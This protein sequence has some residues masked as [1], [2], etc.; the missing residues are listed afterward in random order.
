MPNLSDDTIQSGLY[1]FYN[2]LEYLNLTQSY[3][4]IEIYILIAHFLNN[5][6]LSEV[7]K[8]TNFC[9]KFE[10]ISFLFYFFNRN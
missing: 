9:Q 2:K 10:K 6:P 8:V 1:F 7:G 5:G 3:L 4:I